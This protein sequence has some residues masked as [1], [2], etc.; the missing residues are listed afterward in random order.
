MAKARKIA[1]ISEPDR[2][3]RELQRAEA[4][5]TRAETA[6][7]QRIER[8]KMRAYQQAE[9]ALYVR[10]ESRQALEEWWAN[11][12]PTGVDAA[13]SQGFLYGRIGTRTGE[14]EVKLLAPES[15]VIAALGIG[16]AQYL[17]TPD[18]EIN[19]ERILLDR[20]TLDGL[21]TIASKPD[22]FYIDLE[23]DSLRRKRKK[24]VASK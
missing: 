23:Q 7:N 19:H 18:P 20:F 9:A 6:M 10:D 8:V 1:K 24:E 15:A 21:I 16:N 5:I 13:K 14:E 17:T 2:L 3:L 11:N 4:E 12:K 22:S